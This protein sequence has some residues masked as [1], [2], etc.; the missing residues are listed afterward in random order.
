MSS[1]SSS[2]ASTSSARTKAIRIMMAHTAVQPTTR[3]VKAMAQLA[4]TSRSAREEYVRQIPPEVREDA[5]WDDM[6]ERIIEKGKGIDDV[7]VSF[8]P[9][10]DL[11]TGLTLTIGRGDI[12]IIIAGCCTITSVWHPRG[13][14]PPLMLH[15]GYPI[16]MDVPTKELLPELYKNRGFRT[17]DAEWRGNFLVNLISGLVYGLAKAE[18]LNNKLVDAEGRADK[19]LPKT[20]EKY[21]DVEW[22]D[23]DEVDEALDGAIDSTK[24]ECKELTKNVPLRYITYYR[25]MLRDLLRAAGRKT[26]GGGRA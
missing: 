24:R 17:R 16:S 22:E 7:Q 2:S 9:Q 8:I 12:E 6:M 1:R 15:V 10:T 19:V 21:L 3:S 4:T 20:S 14:E 26:F 18:W 25:T 13:H 23:D 5:F 11:E